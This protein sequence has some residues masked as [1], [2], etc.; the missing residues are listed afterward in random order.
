MLL[1]TD[2]NVNYSHVVTV[3]ASENE[4]SVSAAVL[5]QTK[6]K[7]SLTYFK[8]FGHIVPISH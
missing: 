3:S 4:A 5:F 7:R 6:I 8:K 1:I 2:G